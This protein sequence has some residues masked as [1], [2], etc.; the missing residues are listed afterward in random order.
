MLHL[1]CRPDSTCTDSIGIGTGRGLLFARGDCSRSALPRLPPVRGESHAGAQCARVRRLRRYD[2]AIIG[3]GIVGL[4]TAMALLRAKR[5]GVVVLEAEDR[6]AAHQSG[7]NSGVIH[8]G[9]YYRPGSL[10]A[11]LCIEGRDAM[12]RFCA[13][14]GVPHQRC[15]K[16]IV[17]AEERDLPRLARL[18]E[19]GRANGLGG[20]RSLSAD[21]L[22]QYEPHAAGVAGLF[23]PD[24]G[25]VDFI[26]VT[27]AIADVVRERG[28]DILTSARVERVHSQANEFVLETSQG[29][30]RCRSLIN[31]AGLQ[32]DRVARMCGLEPN[33]RIIPFRGEYCELAPERAALV[34][35]LLY[36]VPDPRLPFVGVH[37]TRR[38]TGGVE[39]GPTAVLTFNRHGY[40]RWNLSSADAIEMLGYPGLWRMAATYWRTGLSELWRSMSRQAFTRALQRLVPELTAADLRPA[41]SGVRAQ[42]V[43]PNGRLVDDFRIMQAQRMIHVLNAPSPAAT[44]SI[45]IGRFIAEM[46]IRAQ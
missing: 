16:V 8:A 44:A 4:A 7:H 32:A 19:R 27:A 28:G 12:Y 11:R 18:V 40:R 6:L 25:I 24:T 14:R 2:V 30:M 21:E 42:A 34:R 38:I 17:A 5:L 20:L 3:G 36:P 29:E 9:L 43:D 39:A 23:V 46:A 37:F 10:K 45:S 41:R 22:R 13:E 1:E 26:A 31:C 35:N 15:G 33:C